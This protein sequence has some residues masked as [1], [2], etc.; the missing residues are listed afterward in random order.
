MLDSGNC[1]KVVQEAEKILKKQPAFS[2]VKV[3]H[4][5]IIGMERRYVDK[6]VAN[7]L[8]VFFIFFLVI[9]RGE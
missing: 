7:F 2:C 9:L 4:F 6:E 3:G 5:F 1:K 8:S